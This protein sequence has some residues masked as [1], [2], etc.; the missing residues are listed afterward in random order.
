MG[1]AD[2]AHSRVALGVAVG[3]ELLQVRSVVLG[4][5]A[6]VMGA[7]S[8]LLGEFACRG[9]RQVLVGPYETAW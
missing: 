5:R 7:Q 9:L 2:D 4:G 3:R 1:D 8:R 6:G